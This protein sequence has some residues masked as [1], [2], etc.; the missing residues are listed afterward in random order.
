MRQTAEDLGL[1][2]ENPH[3]VWVKIDGYM[4]SEEAQNQ[5]DSLAEWFLRQGIDE[6]DMDS[7]YTNDQASPIKWKNH[8]THMVFAFRDPLKATLF[9]LAWG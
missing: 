1:N 8:S 9:K 6:G 7:V 2:P 4:M 3:L 5:R